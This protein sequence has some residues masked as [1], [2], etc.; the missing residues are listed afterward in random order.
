MRTGCQ[1]IPRPRGDRW[2]IRALVFSCIEAYHKR[3]R[4]HSS[5]DYQAPEAFEV[6]AAA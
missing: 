5:I 1:E 3:Q 4:L 2:R 6:Q